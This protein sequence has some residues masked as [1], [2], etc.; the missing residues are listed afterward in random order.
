MKGL[1]LTTHDNVTV[2]V[3][4]GHKVAIIDKT[5]GI[6]SVSDCSWP[7]LSTCKA[8]NKA[9][10]AARLSFKA[11]RSK[12]VIYIDRSPL[13]PV[14]IDSSITSFTINPLDTI[15]IDHVTIAVNKRSKAI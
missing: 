4:H 14:K 12:G 2:S 1:N 11:Y 8:I 6:V 3:L 13:V 10:E 5:K 15:S 7:T 9:F